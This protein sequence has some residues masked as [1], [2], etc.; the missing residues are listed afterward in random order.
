MPTLLVKN[1]DLI[2][3]MDGQDRELKDAA[4]I[5]GTNAFQEFWYITLALL[6]RITL[7]VIVM[8]VSRSFQIFGQV[9]IMTGGGPYGATRVLVQYIYENGFKYWKMGYA[10][11]M[12]YVMLAFNMFFTFLQLKIGGEKE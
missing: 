7:F 9:Y 3:T 12:A 6:R 8:Q 10:S 5:D 11:A 2:V 4:K 1:A